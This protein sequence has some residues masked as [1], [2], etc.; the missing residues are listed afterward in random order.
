MKI[1]SIGI[2]LKRSFTSILKGIVQNEDVQIKAVISDEGKPIDYTTCNIIMI[3]VRMPDYTTEKTLDTLNIETADA[4]KGILEFNLP[5]EFTMQKGVHQLQIAFLENGNIVKTAR[6]NYLVEEGLI[7]DEPSETEIKTTEDL[8]KKVS[9]ALVTNE[10]ISEAEN[11]RIDSENLRR[12]AENLRK[13]EESIRIEEELKRRTSERNRESA[14]EKR[15][16][17]E[18]DRIMAED[19]RILA[20]TERKN[21]ETNRTKQIERLKYYGDADIIPSNESLFAFTLNNDGKGYSIA[22]NWDKEFQQIDKIVIPYEHNG[23]PVVTIGDSAFSECYFL[24]SITIPDSVTN[25]GVNAFYH[26]PLNSITIPSNVTRIGER[27][28]ESC[29][30]LTNVEIPE[31]VKSIDF[32]AFASCESLTKVSIPDNVT[33]IGEDVFY[34]CFGVSIICSQGSYAEQYAK[35]N[36][37][38]IIYDKVYMPDTVPTENSDKLITSGGVYDALGELS[39]EGNETQSPLILNCLLEQLTFNGSWHLSGFEDYE[40]IVTAFQNGRIVIAQTQI[41]SMTKDGN[42]T[43]SNAN[44]ICTGKNLNSV[45]QASYIFE[46]ISEENELVNVEVFKL[47]NEGNYSSFATIR[48]LASKEYV[49]TAIGDVETSLENIIAKYGLGGEA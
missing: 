10:E 45:Y 34:E 46:G 49:G 17:S 18:A 40:A 20:E 19:N 28:F 37:I 30:N 2:D 1:Y 5:K 3:A 15:E 39:S 36:E 13:D 7:L 23:L 32:Y 31:S 9:E 25:I 38:N 24:K 8:L 11:T 41:V 47:D 16:E 43:R 48:N 6:F 42:P 27:A 4:K 21:N 14:E 44:L 33:S 29:Y 12:N 26:C 22:A 35:E